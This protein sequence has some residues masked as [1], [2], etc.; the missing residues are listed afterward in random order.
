MLN[1]A[2]L[3]VRRLAENGSRLIV[4]GSPNTEE[5]AVQNIPWWS[6][7]REEPLQIS[8]GTSDLGL[9]DAAGLVIETESDS[10]SDSAVSSTFRKYH[11]N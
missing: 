8:G 10:E 3:G 1:S 9:S 4:C 5:N 2:A 11:E 7:F 6:A